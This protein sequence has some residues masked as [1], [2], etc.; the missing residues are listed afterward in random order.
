[1]LLPEFD[2]VIGWYPP[3][4]VHEEL[5]R[6]F[7]GYAARFGGASRASCSPTA[8]STGGW[9]RSRRGSIRSVDD[10]DAVH[11]LTA[12][13]G[14]RAEAARAGAQGSLSPARRLRASV[15]ARPRRSPSRQRRPAGRRA[16]VLRLDGRVHRPSLLRPPVA[17]VAEGRGDPGSA[18]RRVSRRVGGS[19]V[20]R[21]PARGRRARRDR[22][23]APPRGLLPA[24]RRQP[25]A[26]RQA[27]AGRHAPVPARDPRPRTALVERLDLVDGVRVSSNTE[28]MRSP[29]PLL[30]LVLAARS[31][32]IRGT[33]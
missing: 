23:P 16:R 3:L 1:M 19:R 14:R 24:D 13:R 32:R 8:V 22:D 5:F 12:R 31:R 30:V 11:R 7:A 29:L 28:S 10:A 20:A 17:A 25:R 33:G 27:G 6:R 2:D 4:D 18:P 26:G 21:A 15:R 9:T